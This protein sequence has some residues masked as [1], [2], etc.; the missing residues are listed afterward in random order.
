M[1]HRIEE[2]AA[3]GCTGASPMARLDPRASPLVVFLITPMEIERGPSAPWATLMVMAITILPFCSG[4][5]NDRL[6]VP[7]CVPRGWP[8]HQH[9]S[10]H[11]PVTKAGVATMDLAVDP[12]KHAVKQMLIAWLDRSAEMEIVERQANAERGDPQRGASIST[13][14]GLT[15]IPGHRALPI[16]VPMAVIHQRFCQG[17]SILTVTATT[18][19][20][21]VHIVMTVPW[22]MTLGRRM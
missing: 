10:T 3:F 7:W 15:F 16:G 22:A 13:E 8:Q 12:V 6:T 20:S 21:L 1:H 14:A 5:T 11:R 2:V 18:T 19:S 4:M 17:S 9:V